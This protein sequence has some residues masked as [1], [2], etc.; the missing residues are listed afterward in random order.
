MAPASVGVVT[1][2]EA[3]ERE[4]PHGVAI[5]LVE[6]GELQPELALRGGDGAEAAGGENPECHVS[7]LGEL[8][9]ACLQRTQLLQRAT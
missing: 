1:V 4:A 9:H 2:R 6:P 3:E 7:S 8:A 5:F